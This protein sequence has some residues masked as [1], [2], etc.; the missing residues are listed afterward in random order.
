MRGNPTSSL[1]KRFISTE[2]LELS[3]PKAGS[4]GAADRFL[5]EFIRKIA[6][7]NLTA[8]TGQVLTGKMQSGQFGPVIAARLSYSPATI[9]RSKEQL[10]DGRDQFALVINCGAPFVIEKTGEIVGNGEAM[11]RDYTEHG[12]VHCPN[13]GELLSLLVPRKHALKVVPDIE[14]H[15]GRRLSG[16]PATLA[17]LRSYST[18][19]LASDPKYGWPPQITGVHLI[20]IISHL[21]QPHAETG[22]GDAPETA[23]DVRTDAIITF[24]HAHFTNPDFRLDDVAKAMKISP[25]TVQTLLERRGLT[26]VGYISEARLALAYSMLS[27]PIHRRRSIAEVALDCGFADLS[28]FNRAFRRRFGATPT[29]VRMERLRAK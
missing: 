13:G 18:T 7:V 4:K 28:H 19:I 26:F 29:A 5:E 3:D 23:I 8:H 1:Q 16:D 10:Q 12:R 9:G 6:A 25:R 22:G 17:L 21:L 24:M 2:L 14:M 15:T 20:D 27:N 11:L